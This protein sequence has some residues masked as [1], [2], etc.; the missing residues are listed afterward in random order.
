MGFDWMCIDYGCQTKCIYRARTLLLHT[1]NHF[2][3]N[4]ISTHTALSPRLMGRTRRSMETIVVL[5][6][7]WGDDIS[8]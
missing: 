7:F 6:T 8:K 5:F 1:T 2:L 3:Y 4:Q